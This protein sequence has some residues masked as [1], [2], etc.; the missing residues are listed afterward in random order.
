MYSAASYAP[1]LGRT[2]ASCR[3]E[4][5]RARGRAGCAVEGRTA[6][7]VILVTAV[8]RPQS[9]CRRGAWAR[10]QARWVATVARGGGPEEWPRRCGDSMAVGPP[11]ATG[12]ASP[13]ARPARCQ[14]RAGCPSPGSVPAGR[15]R[16]TLQQCQRPAP[17]PLH[18]AARAHVEDRAE[19]NSFF[20]FF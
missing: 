16:P 11:S 9:S 2:R 8:P 6:L 14:Q 13:G 12:A 18:E 7:S 1:R 15:S 3:A 17:V 19:W 5:F 10:W 20:I 4:R